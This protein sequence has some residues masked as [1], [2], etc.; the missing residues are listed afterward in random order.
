MDVK[1]VRRDTADSSQT[2]PGSR[3]RGEMSER[4]CEYWGSHLSRSTGLLEVRVGIPLCTS[5]NLS[6]QGP[7]PC[8]L[9]SQV[10]SSDIIRCPSIHYPYEVLP[11]LTSKSTECHV[12]RPNNCKVENQIPNS[13]LNP[14]LPHT[15]GTNIE[16][17]DCDLP[18]PHRHSQGM[19]HPVVTTVDPSLE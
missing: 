7:P 5:G 4:P 3:K 15:S 18:C 10:I 9:V 1:K 6:T 14:S 19:G 8:P 12:P 17:R 11:R 13:L 2:Y 16:T